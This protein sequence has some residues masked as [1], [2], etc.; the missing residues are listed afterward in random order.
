MK[1]MISN[2]NIKRKDK[3]MLGVIRNLVLGFN[4]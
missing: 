2:S 4:F 1:I 3:T